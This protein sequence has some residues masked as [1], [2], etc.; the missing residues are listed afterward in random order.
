MVIVVVGRVWKGGVLLLLLRAAAAL[1]QRKCGDSWDK[2]RGGVPHLGKIKISLARELL[3]ASLQHNTRPYDSPVA[4]L[5]VEHKVVCT[6]RRELMV[7]TLK[8]TDQPHVT[9][10][11][12]RRQRCAAAMAPLQTSR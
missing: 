10:A 11:M 2:I 3:V 12:R 9:S 1:G 6:L 8:G 4:V 5:P 7:W